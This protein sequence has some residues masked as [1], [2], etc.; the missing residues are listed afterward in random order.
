[1]LMYNN[2][3]EFSTVQEYKNYFMNE[4]CVSGVVTHQDIQVNFYPDT[5]EHA[6]YKSRNR[7][8]AD[9]SIFDHERAR[10]IGWIKDVLIDATIPIYV[11]WDSKRKR[12]D[13]SNK[14]SLITT[15][16]YVVV[17][18]LINDTRAKFV[19]AYLIDNG[20]VLDKICSSPCIYEPSIE[21][22]VEPSIEPSVEPSV[23]PSIEPR[24]ELS[25]ELSIELS[26]EPNMELDNL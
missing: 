8:R 21:P 23:E 19:T 20:D 18:R 24:I 1:M 11:G 10:R 3:I 26:V 5:F 14:V 2:L 12:Y 16:G 6:F 7:K 4:Y 17:I 13:S 25:V 15:D 22:S 9:K